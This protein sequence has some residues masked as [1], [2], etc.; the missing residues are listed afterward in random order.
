MTKSVAGPLQRSLEDLGTPLADVTFCIVDL[1]T[2]GI[3]PAECSITEI[4]AV[5]LRGG[6]CLGTFSRSSTQGAESRR[7]SRS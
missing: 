6:E 2:T 5:K 4:G 7:P 3:S 1:E